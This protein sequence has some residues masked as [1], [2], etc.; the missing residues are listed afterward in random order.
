MADYTNIKERYLTDFRR[1]SHLHANGLG[2][3]RSTAIRN[4]ERMGFPTGKNE[5][6]KYTNIAPLLQPAYALPRT[7]APGLSNDAILE[8]LQLPKDSILVV[9]KNGRLENPLLQLPGGMEIR[10]LYES[11]DMPVVK[12]H[13]ARIADMQDDSFSALNTAFFLDGVFIQLPSGSVAPQP[14][15]IVNVSSQ[16]EEAVLAYNRFL[17]VAGKNTA[18]KIAWIT[19]S[20]NDTAQTF[21]NAVNEI[22]VEE[23]ASVE[24]DLFQDENAKA[25][26]VCHTAVHQHPNSRFKINTATLGGSIVRNTLHLNLD[27]ENC[28]THLYGL[29]VASGNQLIDN[30]TAVLH[31]KPHSNSNQ[32]Y[33]GIVGGHAHG[34]FNGKIFVARDAQ[35]TNAYQSNKNILL[36]N[37]AVVNAKPQLEIY[38]DDVKCTHGATTGQMDDDALFY[39]RA[40][41]INEINAKALLNQAFASDVLDN[42]S[43]DSL[44]E[45][46]VRATEKKLMEAHAS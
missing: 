19:I 1:L 25:Y 14:V 3:L 11:R 28:E 16:Q 13:F 8:R 36:S 45:A 15:F 33:K 41:G 6:W 21:V 4:F 18:A 2:D 30:H 5:E 7:D 26:Q 22:V 23:N 12:Q 40:R 9:L 31:G 32:L 10:S 35:K 17:M 39:L 34:V 43:V 29:Y 27:G 38:A 42:I 46:I 20:V 44:R 24:F 37:E